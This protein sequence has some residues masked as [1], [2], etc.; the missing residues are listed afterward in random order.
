MCGNSSVVHLFS[1]SN[2]RSFLCSLRCILS[3]EREM[4][5]FALL[6]AFD[7]FSHF[8]LIFVS[9]LAYTLRALFSVTISSISSPSALYM[10][11]IWVRRLFPYFSLH[12]SGFLCVLY[13]LVITL[14]IV[15]SCGFIAVGIWP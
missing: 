7:E 1:L 13:R 3:A 10:L 14:T 8:F 9:D 4:S 15:I 11:Y 6:L 2:S 5:F 12:F